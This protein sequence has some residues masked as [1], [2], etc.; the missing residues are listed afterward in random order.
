MTEAFVGAADASLVHLRLE[1][2]GPASVAGQPGRLRTTTTTNNHNN[3][4]NNNTN[5]S[6]SNY[7]D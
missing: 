1:G 7:L 2:R 6:A 5:T 4:K 3:N